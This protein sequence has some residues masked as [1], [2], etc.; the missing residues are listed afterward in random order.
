MAEIKDYS[1]TADD[2]NSASPNG[3]PENMAP[4]GVNNSWRESFARVNRWYEDI[5]ATKSTTGS[6]N[7]FY[8]LSSASCMKVSNDATKV[9]SEDST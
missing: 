5:N 7:A 2:N 8:I 3:M 6:S 9:V 4:S 1:V